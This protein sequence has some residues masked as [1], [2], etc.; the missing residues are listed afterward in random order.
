M[1][2]LT[3]LAFMA[4]CTFASVALVNAVNQFN[5]EGRVYCDTCRAGFETNVTEP[6]GAGAKVRIECKKYN[7]VGPI[8]YSVDGITD[9]AGK[10]KIVAQGD[11]EDQTCEVVLVESPRPDCK[12]INKALNHAPIGL[13]KD[14]GIASNDRYPNALGFVKDKPLDVCGAIMKYYETEEED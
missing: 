2:K 9:N 7:T 4:L 13:F 1:A 10:Y 5:V 11:H 12:E 6:I 8:L 3:L 14:N